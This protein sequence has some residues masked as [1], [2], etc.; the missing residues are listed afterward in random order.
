[1]TADT[2]PMIAKTVSGLE[3]LL[4]EELRNL[5]AQNVIEITRAVSFEGDKAL[6]YK[7]NYCVRTALRI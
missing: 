5:G 4:A 2:F 7:A 3:P 1:M 6:M